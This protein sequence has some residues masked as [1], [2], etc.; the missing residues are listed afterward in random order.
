MNFNQKARIAIDNVRVILKKKSLIFLYGKFMASS[1]VIYS[2]HLTILG[3]CYCKNQIDVSFL[4][5]CPL[6]IKKICLN[7]VKVYSL[8]ARGSTAAL[9]ML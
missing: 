9:T 2:R 4:C 7:I 1:P 3:S 8:G 5:V 6:I